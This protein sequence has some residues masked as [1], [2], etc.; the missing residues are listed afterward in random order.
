MSRITEDSVVK[1]TT[2]VVRK[3]DCSTRK[4]GKKNKCHV[5]KKR[6]RKRTI[7][8]ICKQPKAP[9]VHVTT[10]PA[11]VNVQTSPPEVHVTTPEV[12]VT[13]PPPIVNIETPKPDVH[14]KVETPKT[15]VKV[16]VDYPDE[17]CNEEL[18]DLLEQYWDTEV[19]LFTS[20][21]AGSGGE[22]PNRIGMVEKIGK[23]TLILRPTTG[24]DMDQIV[25]FSICHIIGFRPY[26]PVPAL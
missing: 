11:E 14:V 21:G 24:N 16:K 17:S 10:P 2:R 18:R 26:T 6:L 22:P 12:H 1:K 23:S 5:C 20:S 19:E 3:N 13:T 9:I 25:I 4:R 7:K 8:V 15:E